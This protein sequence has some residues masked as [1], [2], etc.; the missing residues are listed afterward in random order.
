MFAVDMYYKKN[1]Y[2]GGQL[3]NFWAP[4]ELLFVDIYTLEN[5]RA[6]QFYKTYFSEYVFPMSIVQKTTYFDTPKFLLYPLYFA[7]LNESLL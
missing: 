4:K 3:R 5:V 7:Y 2:Q 6:N 1:V